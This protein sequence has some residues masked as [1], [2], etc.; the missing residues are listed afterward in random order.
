[1]EQT[2]NTSKLNKKVKHVHHYRT[3]SLCE[4][5][6]GVEIKTENEYLFKTNGETIKFDGFLKIYSQR[7]IKDKIL[8]TLN[9]NDSVDLDKL[10]T[11]QKFTEPPARYSEATLIKALEEKGIGRPSTYAPTISTIQDR[12]YVTK[13]DDRKL[14]PT[15]MGIVVNDL[16]VKHFSDIVDYDFTAKMEN[17]LDEIAEG[18][19]EWVPVIK[20]FYKPFAKNLKEKYNEVYLLRNEEV[21]KIYDFEKGRGDWRRLLKETPADWVVAATR[22]AVAPRMDKEPGWEKIY[23]DPLA[24]LY[25]R[26]TDPPHP[27]LKKYRA[28]RL[29]KNRNPATYHFPG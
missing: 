15:E 16:L 7:E 3:C 4:A 8:P 20:D 22:E 2:I 29:I 19:Q 12:N 10:N 13:N 26:K 17:D 23:Q 18:K 9:E 1:M 14:Q 11:E 24:A 28:G 27:A 21:Y 6:C 25:A 5:M